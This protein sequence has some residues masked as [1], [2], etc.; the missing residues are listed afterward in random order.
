MEK[1]AIPL[2]S[3]REVIA[4]PQITTIPA[5]P[6]HFMGIMNLRGVIVSIVDLRLKLKSKRDD[7]KKP[8]SAVVILEIGAGL[9]LG[10][11]VD[12]VDD[13]LSFDGSQ[14]SPCPQLDSGIEAAFLLGVARLKEQMVLLLDLEKVFS[15]SERQSLAQAPS[16]GKSASAHLTN[17]KSA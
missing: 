8:E 5:V 3:V 14:I 7:S 17:Q 12:S 4:V 2:L 16:D 6:A 11:L 9:N 10:V 1:F 13:V 15:P